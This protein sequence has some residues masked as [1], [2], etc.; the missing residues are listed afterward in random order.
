MSKKIEI[1]E[2]GPRDGLQNE[3]AWISYAN[4]KW[5][6]Q[7]LAQAGLKNMELGAFV[8]RERIPQMA[9]TDRLY[10]DLSQRKFNLPKNTELW[11]LVPNMF[12]LNRAMKVKAKNIAVFTGASDVFVKKNIGMTVEGSLKEFNAVIAEAKRN[13]MKVRGYVSTAF[14][15]PYTGKVLPSKVIRIVN[16]LLD[17]GV[18]QVSV[19]DTI[20]VATPKQIDLVM[21]PLIETWGP[22][23]IA[24]HYHDTRGTS[25]VNAF[26]S[27]EL[28]VRV[29]DSSAG[30]L[31][32]CP[33]APGA[34]GNL[35]TEDLV[36]LFENM[37]I[38][39]GVN[40]KKLCE[41]SLKMAKILKRPLTS[42]YLQ[43][44]AA[45]K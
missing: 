35:A 37:G 4:R 29:F 26:R 36:Y 24:G 11:S 42:R 23:K 41:V 30:G 16:R 38:K 25:L 44:Y 43:A 18:T 17:M 15:C 1:F 22:Q 5:F 6:M 31:G 3:S 33:Y 20:G 32:G 45:R 9:D 2:V 14:G 12:G 13:K 28:G 21:K 40:L 19:G 39:T 34:T 27:Y 8:K 10:Q 7:A